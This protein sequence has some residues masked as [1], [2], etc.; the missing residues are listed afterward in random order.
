MKKYVPSHL[1]LI[2]GK[3]ERR[4]KPI[5]WS[6]LFHD[7]KSSKVWVFWIKLFNLYLLFLFFLIYTWLCQCLL[8]WQKCFA[9]YWLKTWLPD[10]LVRMD[11][12][13]IIRH[14]LLQKKIHFG[15]LPSWTK[16]FLLQWQLVLTKNVLQEENKLGNV[17]CKMREEGGTI[18]SFEE[19]AKHI[20]F[21]WTA[22][23]Q[24]GRQQRRTS[25]MS[26]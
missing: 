7:Y 19:K 1:H 25:P 22:V 2:F 16:N 6:L 4:K 11:T 26:G 20:N 13:F 23:V 15:T 8:I 3:I 10:T 9:E 24:R 18:F 12:A 17:M 14:T 5:L 21:F